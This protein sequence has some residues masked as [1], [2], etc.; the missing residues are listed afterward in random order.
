M[1]IGVTREVSKEKD[2]KFVKLVEMI[3]QLKVV[4]SKR[5]IY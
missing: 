1:R 4:L 5:E 3:K 2:G